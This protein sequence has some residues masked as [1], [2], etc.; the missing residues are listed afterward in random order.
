M[1]ILL[2]DLFATMGFLLIICNEKI[3]IK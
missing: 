1:L 3:D 2:S